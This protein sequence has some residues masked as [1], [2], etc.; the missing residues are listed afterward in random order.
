[1]TSQSRLQIRPYRRKFTFSLS[2]ISALI[3]SGCASPNNEKLPDPKAIQ[4]YQYQAAMADIKEMDWPNQQWWLSLGDPQLTQLIEQGLSGSPSIAAAKARLQQAQGVAVQAG[5][6]QSVHV[7]AE[8]SVYQ[9]KASYNYTSYVP[10]SAYYWN[11][12][13][14]L[15][16]NFSYDLDFW[17]KNRKQVEAAVSQAAAQE[18][19]LASSQLQLSTSIAKAYTE[20]TRLYHNLD[21][22][23]EALQ[24]RQKTTELLTKRYE[25]GL[26]TKGSVSQAQ[27]RQSSAKADLLAVE[28]A[29]DLQKNVLAALVGEGPDRALAIKRP[30]VELQQ[31]I[32]LPENLGVGLIG[33]RPDISAARWQVEAAAKQVGVAKDNF[34]PNVTINA[35]LG[36]QAFGLENLFSSDTSAGN[37]GP[38]IYLPIFNGGQL[39]GQLTAAQAQ[40]K[41]AVSNY[42]QNVTNAFKELADVVTSHQRLEQRLAS[43]RQALDSAQHAYTV[44]S[45]RYQGGLATYLDVLSAENAVL[46]N[47]RALANLQSRSLALH[48]QLVHALGGGFQIKQSDK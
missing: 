3:L 15:G 2:L 46:S 39:E 32:G 23:K 13:A 12:Y 34:Y 17:G 40:Y 44:A 10:E 27:S 8:G 42:D 25:N 29:I 41:L 16:L 1:M 37:I 30:T 28:E 36:Y 9:A 5:A 31:V 4:H 22:A 20:L 45:N 18:A 38:A 47:Q 11:D 24:I 7:N 48:I 43:I 21:T 33:H 6:S 26:E 14:T 19:E 35:F